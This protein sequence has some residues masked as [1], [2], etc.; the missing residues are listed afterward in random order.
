MLQSRS[1]NKLQRQCCRAQDTCLLR[2]HFIRSVSL[3]TSISPR[4]NTERGQEHSLHASELGFAHKSV[5]CRSVC[6]HAHHRVKFTKKLQDMH[7]ARTVSAARGPACA[8]R[9]RN[10]AFLWFPHPRVITCFQKR[11][12]VATCRMLQNDHGRP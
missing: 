2:L 6:R 10:D 7:V 11:S 4:R 3:T 5:L 9:R 8:C 12:S 1:C